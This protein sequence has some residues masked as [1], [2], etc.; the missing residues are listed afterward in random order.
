MCTCS[1]LPL[2]RD[3]TV[4]MAVTG[5]IVWSATPSANSEYAKHSKFQQRIN[6]TFKHDHH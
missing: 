4:G 2:Y 1:K 6:G 3:P 5:Y